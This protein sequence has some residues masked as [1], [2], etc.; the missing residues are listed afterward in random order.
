MGM[1]AR[2]RMSYNNKIS[3]TVQM[4][5]IDTILAD[6]FKS[7]IA[8]KCQI[9]NGPMRPSAAQCCSHVS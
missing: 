4:P 5:A 9:I 2:E 3:E 6:T 7:L 8:W 1:N